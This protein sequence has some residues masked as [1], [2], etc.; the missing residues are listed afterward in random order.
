MRVIMFLWFFAFPLLCLGAQE[1]VGTKSFAFLKIPLGAR[2]SELGGAYT[3]S[4]FGA[5]AVVWNP[6]SLAV[7]EK[8]ELSA[9]YNHYIQ[10][11]SHGFIGYAR[12]VKPE[13]GIAV[14]ATGIFTEIEERVEDTY[15]PSGT[16]GVNEVAFG[17]GMGVKVA[18]GF[19]LGGG[20]KLL[21]AS[22]SDHT[23]SSYAWD[24]AGL[25]CIDNIRVGATI[26]NLGKDTSY[27]ASIGAAVTLMKKSLLFTCSMHA[28]S[29]EERYY[30]AGAQ[31]NLGKILKVRAGW[32]EGSGLREGY[33]VGFGIELENICFDYAFLPYSYLGN[34]HKVTFSLLR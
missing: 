27:D 11:F 23:L 18:E 25:L 12:K 3:A 34:A 21:K 6:A 28:P 17:A 22:L 7:M 14:Y 9:T 24:V 32:T 1:D 26:R 13:F 30:C 20:V 19:Y 10:D 31:V 8:E 2:A 5:D 29:D 16:V 15:S 33:S 4:C